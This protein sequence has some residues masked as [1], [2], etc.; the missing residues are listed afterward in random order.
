M[1]D[2]GVPA[3]IGGG[4]GGGWDRKWVSVGMGSESESCYLCSR[5]V[6]CRAMVEVKGIVLILIK[7]TFRR[8]STFQYL[9]IQMTFQIANSNLENTTVCSHPPNIKQLKW[10]LELA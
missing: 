8:R 1:M 7:E 6:F 3:F 10:N 2:S 5:L 4:S 9:V